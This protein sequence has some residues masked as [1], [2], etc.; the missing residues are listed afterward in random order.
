MAAFIPLLIP[1]VVPLLTELVKALIRKLD[2]VAPP[3]VYPLSTPLTG[4][5]LAP[6]VGVDTEIGAVLGMAG[7]M[8]YETVKSL[9]KKGAV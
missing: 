1:L 8:V 4:M 6:L 2:G 9:R 7:S 3:A 5:A